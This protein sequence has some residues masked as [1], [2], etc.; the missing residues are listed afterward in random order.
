MGLY[1]HEYLNRDAAKVIASLKPGGVLVIEGIHRDIDRN[2]MVGEKYGY[3]N[4]ELPKIFDRLRVKYYEDTTALADWEK[5]GGKPVPIV[6]FIG[7]KEAA[8]KP[9]K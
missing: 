6:R 9:A 1:M 3:R 5:S 4:N 7:V 2:N 8:A